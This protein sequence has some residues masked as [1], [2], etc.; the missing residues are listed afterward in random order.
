MSA[1]TLFDK[2]RQEFRIPSDAALARELEVAP[3]DIC[4]ARK[5]GELSDRMILRVHEYLGVPVV[6]IRQELG[7]PTPHQYHDN[8]AE[9]SA[10]EATQ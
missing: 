2:L 3:P 9:V 6:E 5:T 8:P 4:K 1:S 7:Q 10:T